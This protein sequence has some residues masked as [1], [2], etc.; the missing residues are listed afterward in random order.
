MGTREKYRSPKRFGY[1]GTSVSDFERHAGGGDGMGVVGQQRGSGSWKMPG[2]GSRIPVPLRVLELDLE[3]TQGKTESQLCNS[4]VAPVQTSS[5]GDRGTSS[6]GDTGF[7]SQ[8]EGEGSE[9]SEEETLWANLDQWTGGSSRTREEEDRETSEERELHWLADRSGGEELAEELVTILEESSEEW[10]EEEEEDEE[11]EEEEEEEEEEIVEVVRTARVIEVIEGSEEDEEEV[12]EGQEAVTIKVDDLEDVV[13]GSEESETTTTK[14]MDEKYENTCADIVSEV[15]MREGLVVSS[16]DGR[17]GLVQA[18]PAVIV[19]DFGG[20]S[21]KN[22][23]K[24]PAVGQFCQG[25]YE[26]LAPANQYYEQ[27]ICRQLQNYVKFITW[28]HICH[29]VYSLNVH[30]QVQFGGK[31]P[32]RYFGSEEGLYSIPQVLQ[33]KYD[34]IVNQ[35]KSLKYCMT[36]FV[37]SPEQDQAAS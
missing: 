33:M 1:V 31:G 28:P 24:Q 3:V 30:C 16:N 26:N 37:C 14:E 7:S 8:G 6:Q 4:R 22:F 35:N 23:E 13:I 12:V 15:R 25:E 32:A 2:S 5:Q 9:S 18:L 36:V 10:E 29:R 34:S 21:E 11:D 17:E 19:E 27:V 20:S